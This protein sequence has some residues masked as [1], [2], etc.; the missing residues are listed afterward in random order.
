MCRIT[1]LICDIPTLCISSKMLWKAYKPKMSCKMQM[2]KQKKM[3]YTQERG[4]LPKYPPFL[5]A[6]LEGMS[7]VLC[8][9]TLLGT[10]I[11]NRWLEIYCM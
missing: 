8:H 10:D 11:L 9:N 7:L 1:A 2:K 4:Q 5:S 3:T 6:E